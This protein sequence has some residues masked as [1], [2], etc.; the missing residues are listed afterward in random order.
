MNVII[1][2]GIATSGKST[3]IKLLQDSYRTQ[4]FSEEQTHEPI[5]KDTKNSNVAFF[6]LLLAKFDKDSD[7][8]I[9]D[10]FYLTQ[11]FR[12]KSDLNIY[13]QVEKELQAYLATT[14]FLKVDESAIAERVAK[15]A[16]HRR[17][18]W[19]DY[20]KTRGKNLQEVA[21]YYIKQQR[22]QLELIDQSKLPY[23]V[24]NTTKHNYTKIA[25][26]IKDKLIC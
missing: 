10:R 19:G 1:F 9:C 17:A 22:R 15:A 25:D 4:V 8:V 26:E 23:V 13:N 7:L 14:V 18:T 12:I 3:L 16:E 21:D 24:F 6:E 5:M 2:E 11:A 20:I